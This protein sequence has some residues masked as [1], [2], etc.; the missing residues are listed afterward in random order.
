MIKISGGTAAGSRSHLAGQPRLGAGTQRPFQEGPF[1][2]LHWPRL[3]CF[4]TA[5][6]QSLSP[7]PIC[8]ILLKTYGNQPG[9]GASLACQASG[10]FCEPGLGRSLPARRGLFARERGG[11]I[12]PSPAPDP[13][14]RR[15]GG[16]PTAPRPPPAPG[17]SGARPR[18]SPRG[19][20]AP[21]G[22]AR[23]R[24][25]RRGRLCL[26]PAAPRPGLLRRYRDLRCHMLSG[27]AERSPSEPEQLLPRPYLPGA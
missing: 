4:T 2:R 12:R 23:R 20:A 14:F 24:H 27:S 6:L 25:Q 10:T 1:C 26:P 19:A 18:P 21:A 8:L 11:Q 3:C 13:S 17:P 22:G 7:V 15:A 5:L 9:T 16:P